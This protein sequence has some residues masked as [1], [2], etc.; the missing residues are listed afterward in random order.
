MNA[1][2]RPTVVVGV[3]GSPASV[4]ALR[5]AADEAARLGAQLKIVLIWNIEPRA[6]YAPATTPE[7]YDRR[8]ERAVSGLAATVRVVLGPAVRDTLTVVAQGLPERALVEHSSGAEIL[9]LGS[10]SGLVGGRSIGPVVRACL[11]HAHC[12]VVVV[13]PEGQK[14]H[15]RHGDADPRPD[16]ATTRDQ[17]DLLLTGSAPTPAASGID[18]RPR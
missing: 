11:I 18:G 12:P 1:A 13:G 14:S 5:W 3:S 4:R 10:A 6:Y 15:A 7:D 8:R 17:R 9:V 16:S 2:A